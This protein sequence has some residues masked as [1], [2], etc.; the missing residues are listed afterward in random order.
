LLAPFL[1]FSQAAPARL[2]GLVQGGG[3]AA[4]PLQ[5]LHFLGAGGKAV[6]NLA[7]SGEPGG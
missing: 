3:G 7:D 2:V 4:E 5:G 6:V 1:G